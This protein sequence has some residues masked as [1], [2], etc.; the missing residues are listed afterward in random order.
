MSGIVNSG[1][2]AISET[3]GAEQVEAKPGTGSVIE[4]SDASRAAVNERF[5][6]LE[7]DG[8]YLAVF[9][10]P[11]SFSQFRQLK[12]A[13]VGRKFEYRLVPMTADQ[14]VY[15]GAPSKS[16]PKVQ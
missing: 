6:G 11:D 10:W 15:R 3:S 12:E 1:E 13:L 2:C 4:D 8:D 9:V 7:S 16:K 5:R 14:K